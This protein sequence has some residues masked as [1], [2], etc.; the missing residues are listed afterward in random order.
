[1][2]WLGDIGKS[3]AGPL[4]G[5]LIDAFSNNSAN[6]ANAKM[7]REQMAFQ[8]RMSNTEMQRRVTDLKA[9]GLNPMLAATNQQGASSPTGAR[10][11]NRPVTS[12]SAQSISNAMLLKSQMDNINADTAN[13]QS[14]TGLNQGNT[15]SPGLMDAKFK[16]DIATGLQK[17]ESEKQFMQQSRAEILKIQANVQLLKTQI[18]AGNI[19]NDTLASINQARLNLYVLQGMTESMKPALTSAQIHNLNTNSDTKIPMAEAGKGV[20]SLISVLQSEITDILEDVNSNEPNPVI[21]E[22]KKAF[23]NYRGPGMKN[24]PGYL[25]NKDK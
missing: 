5:G 16:T 15:L 14:Q 4:T 17:I 25:Y 24:K 7:A 19:N 11:E 22:T 1:M 21:N 20:S 18:K 13:K 23:F 6:K 10:S 12:N 8:E 2:G 3:I 9:A